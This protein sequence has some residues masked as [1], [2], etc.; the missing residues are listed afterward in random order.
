MF[1]VD[2]L[3]DQ[4]SHSPCDFC[5][6]CTSKIHLKPLYHKFLFVQKM[7]FCSLKLPI[8]SSYQCKPTFSL[9]PTHQ[10]PIISVKSKTAIKP[11]KI[12]NFQSFPALQLHLRSCSRPMQCALQTWF[13]AS[14][15]TIF[16]I[17][18]LSRLLLIGY[19]ELLLV[20]TQIRIP[21]CI[22]AQEQ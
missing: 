22:W 9:Q 6:S 13:L 7:N 15:K 5:G 17:L 3:K 16:M 4:V 2:D 10:T 21:H 19:K 1:F 12:S 18:S 11:F 8:G 14:Q 20:L